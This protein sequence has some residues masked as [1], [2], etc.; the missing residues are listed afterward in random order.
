MDVSL[1]FRDNRLGGY[2][3]VTREPGD[4]RMKDESQFLYRVK[5]KLNEMGYD[6]IKK[7]MWKDGHM[8]AE[9]QLYLRERDTRP[10][11]RTLAIWN[12]G[13]AIRGA[14]ADFNTRGYVTL[15]VMDIG[16]E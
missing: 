8:V 7:R 4:K 11:R 15:E 6:F 12:P 10:G 14:E 13:W 5:Q 3:H 16:S 9:E 2:C 1:S